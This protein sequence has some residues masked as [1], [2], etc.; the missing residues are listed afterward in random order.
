ME[1]QD[2]IIMTDSQLIGYLMM[3]S[4]EMLIANRDI[5]SEAA[6]QAAGR[7]MCLPASL[8]AWHPSVGVH[9]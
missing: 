9:D 2:T 6:A 3:L 4:T 5:M 7:I 8:K 1:K